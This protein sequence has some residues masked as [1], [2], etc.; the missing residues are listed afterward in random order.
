MN[1]RLLRR[2]LALALVLCC[3]GAVGVYGLM[4]QVT[5]AH[6]QTV[7]GLVPLDMRPFGYGQDDVSALFGALGAPGRNYYLTRQ[8]PLDLAY[9]ALMGQ[10]LVLANM[11]FGARLE[12]RRF[13]AF[14]CLV[15]T[16]AALADY[17]EN[18]G[19]V[20]M[21]LRWPEVSETVINLSSS[22]TIAKSVLTTVAVLSTLYVI[23]RWAHSSL[24]RRI[25]RRV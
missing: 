8:I 19:I 22:A 24:R 18:L 25:R 20:V 1:I 7:S 11:W 6:L 13:L 5:L 10:S 23:L 15:A 4:V 21:I 3:L 17:L 16:L 9:P 14:S 12:Q 2:N